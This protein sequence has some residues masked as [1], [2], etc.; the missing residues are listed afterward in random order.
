MNDQASKLRNLVNSKTEV[1]SDNKSRII[2]V[3]SGKGGVGK[4]NFAVNVGLAFQ[5]TG[6]RVLLI[7]GDLG[8]ANLD[9]LLGVTPQYNLTHVLKGQCKFQEAILEGPENLNLM[10]GISGIGDFINTD[11]EKIIKLLDISS[12]LE[13]KYDIILI[14]VGAGIH[15]SVINFIMAADEA[16][17]VL[18]P[19]PPAIM[20]AYSLIKIMSKNNFNKKLGLLINKVDSEKESLK[21]FERMSE[22]IKSYLKIDITY[23]GYLPY[24]EH[25]KKSVKRQQPFISLYPN[26][27]VSKH[28]QDIAKELL[29]KSKQDTPSGAKGFMYRV[30]GFFKNN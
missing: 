1:D 25:I 30:I 10:P 8:M 24:D 23:L 15:H 14:D 12:H 3:A 29:N 5:Q 20:D 21:I 27:Q 17:I 19:E 26:S 22:V 9:I 16:V 6:E 11:Q 7:D 13:E 18:T 28:L 4:S 2:T